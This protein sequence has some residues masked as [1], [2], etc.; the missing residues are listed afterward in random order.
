MEVFKAGYD[1]T[2]QT[3]HF[4]LQFAKR[5]QILKDLA[6]ID[7]IGANPGRRK[8]Y[9]DQTKKLQSLFNRFWESYFAITLGMAKISRTTF[10]W[11]SN[12]LKSF[13]PIC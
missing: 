1:I 3:P 7:I 10:C 13:K 5:L 11:L 9:L 8:A 4:S 6:V 12:S 2:R